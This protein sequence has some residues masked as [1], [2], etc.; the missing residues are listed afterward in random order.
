MADLRG[1][2]L[3]RAQRD[4]GGERDIPTGVWMELRAHASEWAGRLEVRARFL[5]EFIDED[6]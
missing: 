4:A 6:R 2:A 5:R 1:V 3:R